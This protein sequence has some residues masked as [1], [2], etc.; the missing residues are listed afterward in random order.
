M[1]KQWFCYRDIIGEDG[2]VTTPHKKLCCAFPELTYTF[3][4]AMGSGRVDERRKIGWIDASTQDI[5]DE[6]I[7]SMMEFAA[8][9]ITISEAEA[10]LEEITGHSFTQNG[11]LLEATINGTALSW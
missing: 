6:V 2:A 7:S 8:K 9:K 3:K 11:N 1:P 4:T 5:C 10:L